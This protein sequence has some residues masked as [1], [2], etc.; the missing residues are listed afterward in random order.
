MPG[1]RR[2]TPWSIQW[3]TTAP[4]T[5]RLPPQ[6]RLRL[7]QRRLP[8]SPPG[9]LKCRIEDVSREHRDYQQCVHT[10]LG[11]SERSQFLR[12]VGVR[13][14]ATGQEV[15]GEDG[16][17]PGDL[18]QRCEGL[19]GQVAGPSGWRHVEAPGAVGGEPP[20]RAP[21]S[22][23]PVQGGTGRQDPGRE[24][25]QVRGRSSQWLNRAA[26]RSAAASRDATAAGSARRDAGERPSSSSL[27]VA[28]HVAT[29]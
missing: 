1:A 23:H 18:Q 28:S 4:S 2:F 21:A 19:L 3:S 8:R 26:V 13:Q 10:L 14:L 5:C 25:G 9:A 17:S 24:A 27:A 6:V 29:V 7:C 20:G 16:E 15:L 11:R 22:M 12:L